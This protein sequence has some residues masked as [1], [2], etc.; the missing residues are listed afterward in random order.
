MLTLALTS[1]I[2]IAFISI[3]LS[4]IGNCVAAIFSSRT[5]ARIRQSWP[6]YVIWG[7]ISFFILFVSLSPIASS[8]HRVK[9]NEEGARK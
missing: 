7:S 9:M 3:P 6:L 2:A 1:V 5:R 8:K 4:F